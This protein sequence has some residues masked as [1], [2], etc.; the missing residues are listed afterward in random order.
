M[1]LILWANAQRSL[2]QYGCRRR[3][4]AQIFLDYFEGKDAEY[5]IS[6]M[7][8]ARAKIQPSGE[9]IVPTIVIKKV[10][11]FTESEL[12][13][14]TACKIYLDGYFEAVN[15]NKKLSIIP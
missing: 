13:I 11:I 2:I 9:I 6:E 12:D 3:N 4:E 14:E 8:K 10:M 1:N 15:E 5:I 7:G